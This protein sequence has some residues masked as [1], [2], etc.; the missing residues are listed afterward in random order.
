M[1]PI[2]DTVFRSPTEAVSGTSEFD[3]R[4]KVRYPVELR[5]HYHTLSKKHPFAG[6]G[7]TGNMSTGGLLIVAHQE[8][9]LGAMVEVS[10]EWP[11]LLDGDVPLQLVMIGRVVRCEESSF[12]ISLQRHEFRTMKR[13]TDPPIPPALQSP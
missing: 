11:Y 6:D 9:A 12:A 10:M 4:A 8:L 5:V 1:G 13:R 7:L 2:L 3:R